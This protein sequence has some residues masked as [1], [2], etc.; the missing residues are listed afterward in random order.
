MVAAKTLYLIDASAYVYRAFFA[1][2]PLTSPSG[3][4]TN[5]VYGFTTMLLKLLRE[6]EAKYIGAI[7][8][9]PEPTF[10][11]EAYPAYKA[12]RSAA[13]A[14]LVAQL[15]LV[16]EVL[17]AFGVRRVGLA[18]VE[19]DDIIATLASRLSDRHVD[20]VVITADKDLM[21]LVGDHV[22][23]WDTM[24]DRWV[25]AAEVER[26]FGVPPARVA[27][28]LGLMG[29]SVDNIPG[30]PGIGEKTA[31]ALVQ[32]F[33]SI[34]EI[35]S[36]LDEVAADKGLRGAKKL[37]ANLAEHSELARLSRQLVELRHDVDVSEQLADFAYV[38]ADAETLRPLF[39]RLGF[40][41][42][43]RAI[44][45]RANAVELTTQTVESATARAD[46]ERAAATAARCAIACVG[47]RDRGTSNLSTWVGCL[48][49][50]DPILVPAADGLP[51]E[52]VSVLADA[53][54]VKVCHDLKR[55]LLLLPEAQA[56]VLCNGFDVMLASYLTESSATHRLED[57]ASDLLGH[58]VDV[59]RGS[60]EDV[61]R[62]VVE[63]PALHDELARR[64]HEQELE[65]LFWDVEM[66]LVSVLARMERRG[67]QVDVEVLR[68]LATEV[69]ERLA[70]LEAEIYE[71]AGGPFNIASPPQ[72][73]EV[74]FERL[75]LPTKGIKK[76]KTGLSTDVDVLSKLA[77]SHPLPAR[78]L[79]HRGLA[80]LKS[81][82]VEALPAAV[83]PHTGR[84]HTTFNQTVAATG[85]LSSTD[86]NLQ[87]IPVRTEEGRRI[88]S[89]FVAA[90]G[91]LLIG[92]DYSQIELR[93][94]AHLSGDPALLEAFR[95]DQD[96]HART[97][98]EVFGVLP[99]AVP[100]DLRRAAKVI[101]FGII[102]GMGPQRLARELGISLREA[103][104]YIEQYFA[105]Y[106]GVRAYMD[107]TRAE[108]RARG[109]VTTILGRRRSMAEL[110]GQ[111]RGA[112]Q[113][114]ERTA[115]NTPLQGSAADLIKVAMVRIDARLRR[116]KRRAA[117]LLQVH[118]ELLFE[119]A[120]SEVAAVTALVREEMEQA[121]TL[122]VPLRVDVRSGKNWA[123][124]H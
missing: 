25:D 97:A 80:K 40:P 10:R 82:Y 63:L 114:A 75:G 22:R 67:V 50:S 32:R 64:L 2:P 99:G 43:L 33:G 91:Y 109:Y 60:A 55:D 116:E 29:D 19:A 4:P 100:A 119:V 48:P 45:G 31:Q 122:A 16:F 17:E 71:I 36:R 35:L 23:L 104:Q 94:L 72:L 7:F 11:H 54:I 34:E 68:H 110:T 81:T 124:V 102:Y 3:E 113:A 46:F 21:Q 106:A 118:D 51:D 57:L 5:A 49:G 101:N 86:P 6:T 52:I 121:Q 66:P 1:L 96:V 87:N 117:M 39:N 26:R 61:A 37:A 53:N 90:E 41:S 8:D 105:R 98:S 42:L 76:G 103:Q 12:N 77:E 85:R 9:R 38:G 88:R 18:G 74:L 59:F 20:T 62:G 65:S 13:P 111:D 70:K 115:A 107:R 89:A 28:V 83:D 78:I 112:Q 123:E 92:A 95:L 120:A 27:D 14:D 69:D 84:L 47:T 93:L 15:P 24:R 73:R 44:V 108:A 56:D 30:V 58:R 79:D